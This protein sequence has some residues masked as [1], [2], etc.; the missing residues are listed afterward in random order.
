[1]LVLP[2]SASLPC[3]ITLATSA[4]LLT[5]A[6]RYKLWQLRI[7]APIFHTDLLHQAVEVTSFF[8]QM[9][10]R[11]ASY[12]QHSIVERNSVGQRRVPVDAVDGELCRHAGKG[13]GKERVTPPRSDYPDL[14]P[15]SLSWAGKQTQG[16]QEEPQEAMEERPWREGDRRTKGCWVDIWS[17]LLPCLR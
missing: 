4:N 15:G 9:K 2:L 1:M 7:L 14:K 6:N 17:C 8:R 11:S 3:G 12:L 5:L 13:L 16:G 10:L